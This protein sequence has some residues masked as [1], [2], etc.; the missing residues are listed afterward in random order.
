MKLL[1]LSIVQ[2]TD[3]IERKVLKDF[4]FSNGVTVPAGVTVAVPV[5]AIHH[6]NVSAVCGVALHIP[7][8]C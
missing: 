5:W 7:L 1:N 6:D 4:T 2:S 3:G 8:K